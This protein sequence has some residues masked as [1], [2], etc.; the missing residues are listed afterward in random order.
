VKEQWGNILAS[1]HRELASHT[2]YKVYGMGR[3]QQFSRK[4]TKKKCHMFL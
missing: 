4:K 2:R 3:T 1:Q